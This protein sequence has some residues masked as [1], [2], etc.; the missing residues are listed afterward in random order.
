M[1]AS[2]F[3]V[4]DLTAVKELATGKKENCL[5]L[6]HFKGVRTGRLG[7]VTV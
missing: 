7:Y 5:W 2:I 1:S 3:L 4:R 6:C